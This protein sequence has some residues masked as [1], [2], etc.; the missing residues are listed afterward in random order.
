VKAVGLGTNRAGRHHP[1]VAADLV[2]V[3]DVQ[4]V[5]LGAV[6]VADQPRG[7][8]EVLGLEVQRV[9]GR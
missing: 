6:V 7:L 5:E 8:L 2:V 4:V 9:A 1:E 3:A